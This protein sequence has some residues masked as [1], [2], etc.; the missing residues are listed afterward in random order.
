MRLAP[1]GVRHDPVPEQIRRGQSRASRRGRTNHTDGFTLIEVLVAFAIAALALGTLYQISSTS[2]RA[3]LA[4]TRYSGAVL[5]AE[6]AIEV[7]SAPALLTATRMNGRVDNIYTRDVHVM[8]AFRPVA[9]K[10]PAS[11]YSPIR[12]RCDCLMAGRHAIPLGR[13]VFPASR[14]APMSGH[15]P[16]APNERQRGFTLLELLIAV[17]LLALITTML[18]AGLQMETQ[19]LPRQTG[20]L[21]RAAQLPP[22]Y[23]FLRS[24]LADAQP[25]VPIGATSRSIVFDGEPNAVHFVSTGPQSVQIGG[26]QLLSITFAGR[27]VAGD[28]RLFRRRAARRRSAGVAMFC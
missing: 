24:E 28:A 22:V 1:P 2:T 27:R 7:F 16:I 21:D 8:G 20:R 15:R 19:N 6:L 14:P 12:N 9:R 17:V 5:V 4:A 18:L 26:L 10:R 23:D 3:A 25:V 11:S 13:I